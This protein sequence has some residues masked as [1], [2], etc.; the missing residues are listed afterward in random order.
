MKIRS[1]SVK[2]VKNVHNNRVFASFYKYIELKREQT[3]SGDN[4]FPPVLEKKRSEDS[5]EI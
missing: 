5:G 4:Y 2:L 1:S 3:G